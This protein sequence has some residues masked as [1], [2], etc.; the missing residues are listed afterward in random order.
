M[1]EAEAD[2][3]GQPPRGFPVILSEEIDRVV[4]NVVEPILRG[5]VVAAG[6]AQNL[7]SIG[8]ASRIQ[9]VASGH[10][11]QVAVGIVIRGLD[12]ANFFPEKTRLD[13]MRAV[14]LG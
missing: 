1:T 6:D 14:Y 3:Y 7:V 8:V 5:F 11:L 2:V 10:E 12:V 4:G 9:G 13:R